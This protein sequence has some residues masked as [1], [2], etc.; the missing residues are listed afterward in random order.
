M[1]ILFKMSDN[2]SFPASRCFAFE[3]NRGCSDRTPGWFRRR[4]K[5][6]TRASTSSAGVMRAFTGAWGKASVTGCQPVTVWL[7][8]SLRDRNVSALAQ[9]A[10]RDVELDI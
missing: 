8:R 10:V 5:Y 1:E 9:P 7:S 6:C 2:R 3:D 4:E